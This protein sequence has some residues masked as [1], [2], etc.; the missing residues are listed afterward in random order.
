MATARIWA[1]LW[2]HEVPQPQYVERIVDVTVC[3][4]ITTFLRL[5]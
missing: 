5:L 1:I 3:N 2:F 4:H